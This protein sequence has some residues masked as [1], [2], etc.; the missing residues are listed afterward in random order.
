MLRSRPVTVSVVVV[1]LAVWIVALGTGRHGFF[2]PSVS[3]I[4]PGTLQRHQW[5]GLITSLVDAGTVVQ[6]VVAVIAAIAA[7]G[8]AERLMGSARTAIAFVITGLLASALGVG[9]VVVGMQLGEYWSTSVH[10][11]VTLDP[12]TPIA[13][14]LAWASAWASPLWRRRFRTILVAMSSALLLYSGQPADLNLLVAVGLG[15]GLGALAYRIFRRGAAVP[16]YWRGSRQETRTLLAITAVILAIGPL[17]TV[18]SVTRYGVLSPLGVAIST[19]SPSSVDHAIGCVA[20]RIGP[21]CVNQITHLP[22][23]NVG[24]TLVSLLPLALM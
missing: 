21:A 13:G 24:A 4:D 8:T 3:G 7:V 20:G 15:I 11:V 19:A 16:T 17:L 5:W 12:L 18:L 22:V 2:A 23:H 6:L 1:L 9:L 14:T 10:G